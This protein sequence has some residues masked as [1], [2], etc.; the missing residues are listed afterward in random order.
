VFRC[1]VADFSTGEDLEIS[2]SDADYV[3]LLGTVLI[4]AYEIFLLPGASRRSLCHEVLDGFI[5]RVPV[6]TRNVLPGL[7]LLE[8]RAT[9]YRARW[10]TS[11]FSA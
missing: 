8:S 6:R 9:P 5:Q 4:L 3:V 7:E 2:A 11:N 10:R 1:I